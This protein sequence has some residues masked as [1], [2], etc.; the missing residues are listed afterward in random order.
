MEQLYPIFKRRLFSLLVIFFVINNTKAQDIP[1][2]YSNIKTAPAGSYVIAMD[3][4]TQASSSINTASNSYL[5]NL[6]SYGLAVFLLD[7]G[8]PLNWVIRAGKA[9]DEIDFTASVERV[10]PS[11]LAA[12]SLS[13]RSGPIL[14]FPADTLAAASVI[15]IFNSFL[16]DSCKVKVY[17]L[18]SAV[19]VDVRYTLTR[20]PKAALL[21]DSCDVHINNMEMASVPTLN[22]DCLPNASTLRSQCY[23]IA[24]D[25]HVVANDLTS[26]DAD[27]IYNFVMA[28]GNFLAQCEAVQTFEELK[29]YQSLSGNISDPTGGQYNNFNNNVYY[30]NPDMAFGQYQGTYRP[31][32]RGAQKV[33]RYNS[34]NINNFYPVTSCR[35]NS[36][37]NLY[38]VATA[39]KMTSDT[40]SMVFYVGN[41][42]Y[43]SHDC[44]TC[45]G[46]TSVNEAEING[47]RLYL[48]AILIP[49]KFMKCVNVFDIPLAVSLSDFTAFKRNNQTVQLDWEILDDDESTWYVVEH[50]KDGRIFNMIGKVDGKE[51]SGD[52]G[53]YNFIH[54]NPGSGVNYYRIKIVTMGNKIAYSGV[55]KIIFDNKAELLHIFPNPA[56][57]TIQLMIDVRE[58]E[59]LQVK[60]YNNGGQLAASRFII[61]QNQKAELNIETLNKGLYMVVA[62]SAKGNIYRSKLV[63]H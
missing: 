54:S 9:K 20:P 36:G 48:N 27:S 2:S 5:F 23:T 56:K 29:K 24:T 42:E 16:P 7:V 45:V 58:G 63:I 35:R 13:F 43:Y 50:S 49:S 14:I 25:P 10:T 19:S 6:K 62:V 38:Y 34:A 18:Q 1:G 52:A 3:N 41:H 39:S 59:R 40:G 57:G 60:L 22:Y 53:S 31:W 30:D 21:H 55:K 4:I 11:Y 15:E 17:R 47:V 8:Y 37:D 61:I 26:Y 46:G 28:G 51:S 32:I 12:Q 44:H 33:W